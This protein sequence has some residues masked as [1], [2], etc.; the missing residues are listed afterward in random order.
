MYLPSQN[1]MQRNQMHA[2]NQTN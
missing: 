1:E 2:T